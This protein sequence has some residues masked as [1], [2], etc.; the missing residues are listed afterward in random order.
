MQNSKFKKCQ[1]K[2]IFE[3]AVSRKDSRSS[4][5]KDFDLEVHTELQLKIL[6]GINS[7]GAR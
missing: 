1:W 2:I 7:A 5:I 3:C 4:N 6:G